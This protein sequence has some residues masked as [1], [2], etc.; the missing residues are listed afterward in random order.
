VRAELNRADFF[1][2]RVHN[3]DSAIS[4]AHPDI[5]RQPIISDVVRV[6][7]KFQGF[8]RSQRLPF[9]YAKLSISPGRNIELVS[10]RIVVEALW[11]FE[12]FDLGDAFI[13]PC[14]KDFDRAILESG[15]E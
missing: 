13:L 11:F 12:P 1:T 15:N 10:F 4:I 9:V 5:S 3:A 7:T 6:T 14:I 8:P 2:G